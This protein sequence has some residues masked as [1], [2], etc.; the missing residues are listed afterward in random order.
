LLIDF[1]DTVAMKFPY[2]KRLF[3]KRGGKAGSI[4]PPLFAII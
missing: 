1:R 4:L 3:V 2:I